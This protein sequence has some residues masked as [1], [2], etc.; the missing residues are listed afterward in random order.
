MNPF[1]RHC[2]LSVE[3]RVEFRVRFVVDQ[4]APE[5]SSLRDCSGYP[6]HPTFPILIYQHPLICATALTLEPIITYSV[7]KMRPY[8]LTQHSLVTVYES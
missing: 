5:G 1:H 7:I 2:L 8:L 3:L 6:C 4:G